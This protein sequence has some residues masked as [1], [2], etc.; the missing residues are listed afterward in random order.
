MYKMLLTGNITPSYQV[1][2]YLIVLSP[3]EALREKIQKVKQQFY[4]DYKA[5]AALYAKPHISL[6]NFLQF[7]MRE[8]RIVNRLQNISQGYH[9]IRV[10][11]KDYGS[12]PAHTIFIN[13]ASKDAIQSLVKTIRTEA[14][15]LMKLNNDNKP[16]FILEPH[17]NIG[18][19]LQ[20]WQ[21]EKAWLE[22]SHKHFTGKFIADSMLL[23][24]RPLGEWKYQ[25]VKRFEFEN[26]PVNT[27]Q[28]GLFDGLM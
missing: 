5:P 4:E 27:V 16:H 24:K 3:N 20:P 12:F 25:I 9:P 21:Y 6:V 1:Y 10:E 17:I 13:I 2:E 18:L 15:L 8:D 19:K 22:Y 11:M 14:Q 28:G 7:E 26:M 23:L